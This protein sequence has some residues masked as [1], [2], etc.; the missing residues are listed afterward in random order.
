M[1]CV[2]CGQ[3]WLSCWVLELI[4][5]WDLEE[6]V[7]FYWCTLNVR[8]QYF[9]PWLIKLSSWTEVPERKSPKLPAA[10]KSRWCESARDIWA[11][12][13]CSVI[14]V[15][16]SYAYQS[17]H[18]LHERRKT[19]WTPTCMD[20]FGPE[21][22]EPMRVRTTI[23]M[24][25]RSGP[26]RPNVPTV[27]TLLEYMERASYTVPVRRSTMTMRTSSDILSPRVQLISSA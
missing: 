18:D 9:G 24:I 14:N 5:P 8:R 20:R 2:W 12:E 13:N 26:K 1:A 19:A 22:N 7:S 16:L 10:T 3:A 4:A 23:M 15:A 6:P 11:Q 21:S 25:F 27:P 17:R